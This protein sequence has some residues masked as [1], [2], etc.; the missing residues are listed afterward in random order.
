MF[1]QHHVSCTQWLNMDSH[2]NEEEICNLY[3][4]VG[5]NNICFCWLFVSL[6]M[7]CDGSWI[8]MSFLKDASPFAASSWV[9][10]W[11]LLFWIDVLPSCQAVFYGVSRKSVST[12]LTFKHAQVCPLTRSM[13][14][15]AWRSLCSGQ[16]LRWHP[17]HDRPTFCLHL[18]L[19]A[20]ALYDHM[21]PGP[22]GACGGEW[23]WGRGHP[24]HS[25][26]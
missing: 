20:C 9:Y 14:E 22:D 21:D 17:C 23:V 12:A 11:L 7:H 24:V 25:I 26:S 8:Y 1:C 15:H 5:P 6:A 19:S 2:V 4:V 10:P 13:T 3:P 18:P 16:T